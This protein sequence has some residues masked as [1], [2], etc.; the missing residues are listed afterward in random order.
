[1]GF[2]RQMAF[3]LLLYV[4]LGCWKGYVAIFPEDSEEPN[5]IF[6]CKVESLPEADQ[7][8]LK[9]GILIRNERDLTQLLEDYLS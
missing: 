8:M 3:V 7:Q 5:Q 6:P 9:N 4:I 1:M 2:R